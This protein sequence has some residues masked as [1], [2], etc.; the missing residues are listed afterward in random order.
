MSLDT[1]FLRRCIASL[2]R[3]VAE[4]DGL[5]DGEDYALCDVY[6]AACVKE[7][8]LVVDQSSALLL[9]PLAAHLTSERLTAGH[10]QGLFPQAAKHV[11]RFLVD[12]GRAGG[13]LR[14]QDD[15]NDH[16][17]VA[18]R[19]AAKYGFMDGDSVERWL[20]YLD[21]RQDAAHNDDEDFAE[22][23]LALLPAFVDDAKTFADMIER[24]DDD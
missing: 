22:A 20:R 14:N 18:F 12:S 13:W 1:T 21:N 5:D 11:K 16:F 10:F 23:T 4:L 15:R 17:K 9:K 8:E 19:S 3:A 2:E 24:S 6:R 7:F